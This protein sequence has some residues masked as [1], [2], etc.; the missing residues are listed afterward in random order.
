MSTTVFSTT[1]QKLRKEKGVT[2][3]QLAS[4]LGVSAQAVSK[5]EN[6]SYPEG[7][8]LLKLSEYFDV[9]IS[10]LFG[11]EK[12]QVSIEQAVMDAIYEVENDGKNPEG[13]IKKMQQ[14]LWAM[15]NGPWSGNRE[16]YNM[17][18]LD[19]S[20]RTGSCITNDAGFTFMSLNK[21]TPLYTLVK[22]PKEGFES[23]LPDIDRAREFL[24]TLSEKGA[25]EILLY[26]LSLRDSEFV[27]VKTISENTKLP[28]PRVRELIGKIDN[29]A[30]YNC[31]FPFI[32]VL[33]SNSNRDKV[34]G[35]HSYVTGLYLPFLMIVKMFLEPLDG[36]QMQI[37]MRGKPW[38]AKK[39]KG[40]KDAKEK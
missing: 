25:L 26:M 1:L 35:V 31:A 14:I 37:A 27:T 15:Q 34:Y 13:L 36:Y 17:P 18:E 19:I 10:F 5:W 9:S 8:L 24:T 2:Q 16:F 39:A 20:P 28:E 29:E 23:T 22:E 11:Q 38:I 21:N 33:D 40:G 3:E 7:D 30:N 12:K 32:Y 6:G 4:Y